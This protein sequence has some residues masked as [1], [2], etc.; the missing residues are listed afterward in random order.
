ML[1][2][3]TYHLS[4]RR[5]G[6]GTPPLPPPLP[7]PPHQVW[8]LLC[9]PQTNWCHPAR[10]NRGPKRS[11]QPLAFSLNITGS[12]VRCWKHMAT[13]HC[14][15]SHYSNVPLGLYAWHDLLLKVYML[16]P[17][18]VARSPSATAYFAELLIDLQGKH[19]QWLLALVM[20]VIVCTCINIDFSVMTDLFICDERMK[21]ILLQAQMSQQTKKGNL[22]CRQQKNTT[23]LW[24]PEL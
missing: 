1:F 14:Q 18:S 16:L 12:A 21:I 24:I 19:G 8:C 15:Y 23:T 22:D 4:S 11:V 7:P 9:C 2:F 10:T 17:C 20:M 6:Q 5:L 3:T 13:A